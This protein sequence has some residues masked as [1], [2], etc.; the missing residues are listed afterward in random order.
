MAVCPVLSLTHG[1][2]ICRLLAQPTAM[3]SSLSICYAKP[4]EDGRP[5]GTYH[6]LKTRPNLLPAEGR[7]G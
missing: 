4:E 6:T 1:L 7:A 2:H 3:K 5:H